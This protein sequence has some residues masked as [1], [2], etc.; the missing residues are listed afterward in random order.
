MGA[1]A[2]P[3]A[4]ERAEAGR[5]SP[6]R[7]SVDDY[8]NMAEAGILGEDDRVELLDGEIVDMSP[9]GSEHAGSVNLALAG[10]V[11]R[12]PPRRYLVS[13]QNPLRLDRFDEP[14]PDLAVLRWR[15]DGYAR[16]HP[17]PADVLLLIEVMQSGRDYDRRVKLPLYARFGIP[18]VWLVDLS[19][20]RLEVHRDPAPEGY[21]TVA[22]LA[23]GQ[24]LQALLVPELALDAADLL[25]PSG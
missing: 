10:L 13:V 9:I 15:E 14:Q 25:P 20:D 23:R 8:Y 18:E 16:G 21:R 17:G 3:E 4:K 1:I 22:A 12:L 7:F 5:P 19:A 24:K 2:E 6:H 11:T